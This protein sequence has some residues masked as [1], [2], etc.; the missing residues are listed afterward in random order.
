VRKG[1]N[2]GPRAITCDFAA[3]LDEDALRLRL[4]LYSKR[5]FPLLIQDKSLST[6]IGSSFCPPEGSGAHG[7]PELNR[8]KNRVDD[9]ANFF[10]V[11]FAEIENLAFPA[12]VGGKDRSAW[13]A[14][15]RSAIEKNEGRDTIRNSHAFLIGRYIKCILT[16]NHGWGGLGQRLRATSPVQVAI[17]AASL[18]WFLRCSGRKMFAT[19]LSVITTSAVTLLTE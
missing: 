7:D 9:S 16:T 8:R 2:S 3:H 15:E 5:Q 12:S 6:F 4:C 18:I 1:F 17:L 11:N 14:T 10:P 13:T 19:Y